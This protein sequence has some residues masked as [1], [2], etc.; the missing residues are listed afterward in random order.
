MWSVD[1]VQATGFSG[2][3]LWKLNTTSRSVKC[4]E[5]LDQLTDYKPW[6]WG[7]VVRSGIHY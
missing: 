3:L 4:G 7:F 2:A 1:L 6:F 5:F